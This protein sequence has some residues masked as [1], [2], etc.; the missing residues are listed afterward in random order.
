MVCWC[1]LYFIYSKHGDNENG[2]QYNFIYKKNY[3]GTNSYKK[4]THPSSL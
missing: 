2:Y 1:S 3:L 4:L